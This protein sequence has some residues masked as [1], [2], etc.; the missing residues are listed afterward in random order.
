MA[1]DES[2][3][4]R[5]AGILFGIGQ[6]AIDR[7]DDRALLIEAA[8]FSALGVDRLLKGVL[9]KL[10]PHYAY[11]FD[12]LDFD[13]ALAAHH[14]E[15][16]ISGHK[17]KLPPAHESTGSLCGMQAAAHRAAAISNTVRER[18]ST[19]LNLATIRD[20][21]AHRNLAELTDERLRSALADV[22][23]LVFYL[24]EELDVSL[25]D[26]LD[27]TEATR[28]ARL[29]EEQAPER[30]KAKLEVHRARFHELS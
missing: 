29:R 16:V 12:K 2:F 19:V 8:L 10:N 13:Q 7:G 23:A 9:H 22:Y 14:P 15:R 3:H 11:A 25:Y 4:V 28:A 30:V 24:A 26:L 17:G 21:I 5:D 27:D 6:S 1:S 20:A 18:L